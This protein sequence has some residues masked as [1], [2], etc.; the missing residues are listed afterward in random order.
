[1]FRSTMALVAALAVTGLCIADVVAHGEPTPVFYGK[2]ITPPQVD[3]S[4]ELSTD[5][6]AG[7]APHAVMVRYEQHRP[8]YD[9]HRRGAFLLRYRQ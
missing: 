3:S 5:N 7:M 2:T 9:E 8:Y 6:T 1:M 4:P